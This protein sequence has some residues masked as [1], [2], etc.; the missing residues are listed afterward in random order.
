VR[1]RRLLEI[2]ADGPA[3][4]RFRYRTPRQQ[5]IVGQT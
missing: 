4:Q 3:F 5:D 1:E 2:W